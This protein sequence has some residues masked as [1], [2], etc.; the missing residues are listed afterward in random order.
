VQKQ[1]QKLEKLARERAELEKALPTD[2]VVR[3]SHP[4]WMVDAIRRDWPR[5]W[6]SVLAA[7][8]EAGPLTLRVN[9]RAADAR[10]YLLRLPGAGLAGSPVPEAPD[11]V[12][13]ED[14]VPVEKIPGFS[15]GQVSVQDAS[16]QLAA[17][18]LELQPGLRSTSTPRASSACRTR[19]RASSS[20]PK[21]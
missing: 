1:E 5:Q 9:R 16:A 10:D 18:L 2:P 7:N 11:A 6:Q 4:E 12:V 17:E 19:S 15:E 21:C 13:L 20:T 3:W 14:A 8:N